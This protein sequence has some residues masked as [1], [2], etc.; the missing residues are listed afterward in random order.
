[1]MHNLTFHG[2]GDPPRELAPGEAKVWVDTDR[3]LD[4]LDAAAGRDDVCITFDDGNRSD[5]EVALPALLERDMKATFFVLGA[6]LGTPDYLG[7]D[8]VRSLVA[9]GMTIGSH[10]MRHRDWRRCADDELTEELVASRR[11]LGEVAGTPITQTSIPF[12]SYDRRVLSHVRQTGGYERVYTSDGGTARPSDWLQPRRS[13]TK[14]DDSASVLLC[15]FRTP[16][17]AARESAKRL[18]KRWR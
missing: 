14:A 9:V 13:V 2:V 4:I 17:A 6:R 11:I 8:D 12:G 16:V 3:L 15:G 5:V 1:M 18:V 10:G 7:E